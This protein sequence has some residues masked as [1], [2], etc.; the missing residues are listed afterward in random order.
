[1]P[2]YGETIHADLHGAL[3]EVYGKHFEPE[4]RGLWPKKP[5][6]M[7]LVGLR[8][9]HYRY[10]WNDNKI[11]S[12]N[13]SIAMVRVGTIQDPL[14]GFEIHA[15]IFEATTDPGRFKKYY[16]IEGDAWLLPGLY[17]YRLGHHHGYEALNPAG[18]LA[19]AR[20]RDKDGIPGETGEIVRQVVDGPSTGINIHHAADTQGRVGNWSAGC[21]VLR[22]RCDLV[23]IVECVKTALAAAGQKTIPYMLVNA[24]HF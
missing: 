7:F 18:P 22:H 4:H 24:S 2:Q 3:S 12:W 17:F 13:D 21:Q 23:A 19:L 6:E 8:G 14:A 11:D 9:Y 15:A 16:N 5:G 10:G 1:M 20:D